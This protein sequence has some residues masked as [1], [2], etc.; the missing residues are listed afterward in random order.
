M[1]ALILTVEGC[2]RQ[3]FPLGKAT[4]M[5]GKG[6]AV[7]VQLSS[8]HVSMNHASIVL[9]Q[10]GFVLHD[11]GSE[12]GSYVNG[13]L[14]T[15]HSL[16]H[17]DLVRF[18]EYLFLVDLEDQTQASKSTGTGSSSSNQIDISSKPK[19]IKPKTESQSI[20]LL[21]TEPAAHTISNDRGKA[22]LKATLTLIVEGCPPHTYSLGKATLMVGRGDTMDVQLPSESIG[23]N[24][25]S[26][27][28]ESEGFVLHDHGSA[29]GSYVNGVLVTRHVIQN[30]DLIRFG[31][32]LFLADLKEED[33]EPEFEKPREAP[34]KRT[35]QRVDEKLAQKTGGRYHTIEQITQPVLPKPNKPKTS[36]ASE[37]IRVKLTEALPPS[38]KKSKTS[39][40]TQSPSQWLALARSVIFFLLLLMLA[41]TLML[42]FLPLATR[43]NMVKSPTFTSLPFSAELSRWFIRQGDEFREEVKIER[44]LSMTQDFRVPKEA[45]IIGRLDFA[46]TPTVPIKLQIKFTSTAPNVPVPE[47]IA[48]EILP[49]TESVD[50]YSVIFPPGAYKLE[51]IC[52]DDS[53]KRFYKA[54]VIISTFF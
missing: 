52:D 1:P 2:P 6:D 12:N 47:P 50:L 42:S 3:T 18:G 14:V 51:C 9:E 26:I 53:L 46:D 31:E 25:A 20:K 23:M 13:D 35:T 16:K 38:K 11:H 45:R 22:Y 19:K 5:I 21:L 27:V 41:V 30:R 49:D 48:F 24:H 43:E 17:H 29:S 37:G 10:E 54:E 32:Y 4:L 8:D 44:G 34:P 40:R 15:R 28:L 39:S 36:A 33:L 7:D